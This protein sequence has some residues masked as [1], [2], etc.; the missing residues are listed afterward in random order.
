MNELKTRGEK[1]FT[2]FSVIILS[3]LALAGLAPFILIFIASFTKESELILNGYSF[4][5]K[6]LSFD[7]YR[8]MVNQANIIIRAYGVSIV[9]TS[10]GTFV[11]VVITAMLAYPLSRADF[12]YRNLLTFIVFFTMLFSG[13]IV[14]AYIMWT[15]VFAIKN[16]LLALIVPTYLMNAFNVLLVRSYYTN[17]V[18]SSLI[19]SAQID[20]AGELRIFFKIMLPLSIPAIATIGI[21][22]GLAYWNDW[23]NGLYYITK[24]QYFGIQNLLVRMMDNIQYLKSGNSSV[25]NVAQSIQLPSNAVRMALAVIGV[26]PI[27]IIFPFVQKY[28][29]KGVVVGAVKG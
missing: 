21:F 5:P 25:G 23:I 10:V 11:S 26:L 18:P 12:K 1:N 16:T 6:T 24:P 9:V 28:F 29:I 4:F 27:I 2:I 20:G 3:V 7:A 8:Y 22:T 15:R 14:P 13:G 17:N 19:E